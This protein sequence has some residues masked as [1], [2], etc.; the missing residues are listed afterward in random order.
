MPLSRNLKFR[1]PR[2]GITTYLNIGYKNC[3]QRQHRAI[4]RAEIAQNN[5]N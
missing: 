4:I 1:R 2:K 5:E 3:M